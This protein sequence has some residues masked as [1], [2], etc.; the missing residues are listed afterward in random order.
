MIVKTYNVFCDDSSPSCAIWDGYG[1]TAK[2]ARRDVARKGWIRV[3][4]KGKLL[5]ICL[6]CQLPRE[7]EQEEQEKQKDEKWTF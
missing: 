4:R 7:E 1:K 6:K 2:A 5:D 3:H